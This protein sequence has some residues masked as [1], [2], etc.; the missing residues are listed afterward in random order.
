MF[1][2]SDDYQQLD[3]FSSPTEYF[4]GPKKKNYLKNDS[5]HNQFR[6]QVV[7]RVDESIFS[8]LYTEGNGAPN[9]S[10]RVLVGMMILK[11][12]QGWSDRQ[13]FYE[14]GYNLL[15]RSALGLMSLE[16]AE[17]VPSTYYLFRRNLVEYARDHG[18]DLFKKCQEQITRDQILEFN[19]EGK[20][21]RMDS[22]LIGSNIAWYSRY[23]LIHE[24]LRLFIAEREEHIFKKSLPKEMFSL[25]ESIRDEK[26]NKV[27]YRSTKAEIDARF[28]ELGKLMYRLIELFKRYDY[29]WYGT[30]KAVFEQ[31]YSVSED[32][33]VLPIENEKVSAK[34]IQSPHDTDCHYRNKD[35]K[36]VK[37]YSVNITETC[38]QSHEEEAPQ[39]NL[40]TDT[41][42][43]V[44]S[45]PDNS[46]LEQALEH[47]QEIIPD[48]IEKVYADGAY[49]SEYNQEYCQ[50]GDKEIDLVLT[51]MQGAEPRYELS[52]DEQDENNLIVTDN[53]TGITV[54]AQ[55]VK[56]RKDQ[57]QKKW[58]IKTEK[59]DY[60]YFDE[61]SLRV[62]ALRQKLKKIPIEETN[63]RNNVEAS[64]FQ[65]GYHYP[66]NKSRYRTLIKHKL[67]AYSRSLWI[68]FVR[69]VKYITQ[70]CQRSL[71][72][73]NMPLYIADLCFNMYIIVNILS[74]D[75]RNHIFPANLHF[76]AI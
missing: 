70:I 27:V 26:G 32:K 20:Q 69:I 61:N 15:T 13:L 28:V 41:E 33:I 21:V 35:G 56:P 34:S 67:W 7:M 22:K 29:G 2:K 43:N 59:G 62:S 54:Q 25:I 5:W 17:P 74:I 49:H 66:N 12:G 40:I 3:I 42:V 55:Q 19:V 23:E 6:N 48:K 16:D 31:Q 1:K 53:K 36:K 18:E 63:I 58:K 57:T 24:T 38:D 30:L 44:V 4:K 39:L 14:C 8:V 9:A 45:T 65:L 50:E 47:T 76:S 52:L 68:N 10:I 37:G 46:F 75:K 72:G 71:L 11:E 64:I 51:A 60:R 73:Q